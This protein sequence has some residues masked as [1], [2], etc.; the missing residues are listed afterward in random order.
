[1]ELAASG[2]D[3][4]ED[5]GGS[6]RPDKGRRARIVAGEVSGDRLDQ[7]GQAAKDSSTQTLGGQ[8]TKEALH[9][10]EPRGTRG[11]KVQMKA[12][13]PFEPGFDLGMFVRGVVIQDQVQ[14]AIC[15]RLR[16]KPASGT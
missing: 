9:H 1:M 2:F 11:S 15:R 10:V 5:V 14:V 16:I 4:G 13:M 6:G 12:R 7:P 8:V 3:F